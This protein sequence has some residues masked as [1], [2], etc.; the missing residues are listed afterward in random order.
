MLK[1]W[2]LLCINGWDESKTR[3]EKWEKEYNGRKKIARSK[4]LIKEE[5]I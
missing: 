1:K 5:K 3:N 4:V 2:S